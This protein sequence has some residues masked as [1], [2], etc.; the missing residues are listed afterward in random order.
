MPDTSNQSDEHPRLLYPFYLDTDISMA[1]SAALTGGVALEEERLDRA[2]E[3]SQAVRSLRGSLKLWRAGGASAGRDQTQRE[4]LSSEARL[5]RHHT[6]ASV[7][8]DLYDELRRTGQLTEEPVLDDVG[9]GD[10]VSLRM[11]PAVAPLRRVVDQLIR[12]LDLMAPVIGADDREEPKPGNRQQRRA[13]EREGGRLAPEPDGSQEL[14]QIRRL[15]TALKDDLDQSGMVDIAVVEEGGTSSILTLDKRFVEPPTLELLHTSSFTVVGKVTS[16]WESSD[17]VVNL[18]R[19]S[20]LSLL[21]SLTQATVWAIFSFLGGIA[22]GL[23]VKELE[24]AAWESIGRPNTTSENDDSSD[25][26]SED[27]PEEQNEIL[28]GADIEALT[29]AVVGPAI[30]LLP[31][32]ICS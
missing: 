12:L 1:F 18:Y 5:I 14:E 29:P 28:L 23:D 7:F 32:A 31:M 13:R 16:R 6:V 30:Q 22:S 9:V 8:I 3:A 26:A 25:A 20:V 21:P 19:R 27:K 4:E 10:L 24:S 15:L 2:G 17:E 11:G